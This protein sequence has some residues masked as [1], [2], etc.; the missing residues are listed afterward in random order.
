V[1]ERLAGLGHL[2]N[3]NHKPTEQKIRENL[4]MWLA[5]GGHDGADI[6]VRRSFVARVP[7]PTPKELL[8]AGEITDNRKSGLVRVPPL[9]VLT[10]LPRG[11]GLRCALTLPFLVQTNRAAALGSQGLIKIPID[12]DDAPFDFLR[13]IAIPAK[14]RG[15]GVWGGGPRANRQRQI[16]EALKRLAEDDLKMIALPSG[17]QGVPRFKEVHLRNETGAATLDPLPYTIP[18]PNVLTVDIP[19][20]FFTSGWV[21]ALTN[22]EIAMWLMIRD[23][24]ARA[25]PAVV[26]APVD[27]VPAPLWDRLTVYDVRK[28]TADTSRELEAFGLVEVIRDEENRRPDGTTRGGVRAAPNRYRLTDAGLQKPAVATVVKRLRS[29][30]RGRLPRQSRA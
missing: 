17:G 3:A 21:H 24:T 2:R 25:D 11:V 5:D 29:T 13:L 28:R 22:R 23:L 1:R 4:G 26:N 18:K 15:G 7:P 27:G 20:A 8:D 6:R 9:A 16:R 19:T 10:A 30:G 14:Y 12:D